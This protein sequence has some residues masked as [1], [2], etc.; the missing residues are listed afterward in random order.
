MR[1][2]GRFCLLSVAAAALACAAPIQISEILFNPD[3][4]D[5]P[6]EYVELRGTPGAAIAAGTYLVG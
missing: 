6:H 5:R 4:T 3:G 2:I 1:I